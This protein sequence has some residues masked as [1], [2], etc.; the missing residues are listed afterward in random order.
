MILNALE[1]Y[2]YIVIQK[3]QQSMCVNISFLN[4][5]NIQNLQNYTYQCN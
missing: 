5:E 1:T 2:N 3:V 4:R